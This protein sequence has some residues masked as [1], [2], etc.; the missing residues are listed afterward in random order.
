MSLPVHDTQP[1]IWGFSTP[2]SQDW[3]LLMW[4]VIVLHGSTHWGQ[5]QFMSCLEIRRA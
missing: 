2:N 3:R 4:V 5:W 1:K